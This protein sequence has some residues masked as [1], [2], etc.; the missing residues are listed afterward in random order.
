MSFEILS[1]K[2][3]FGLIFSHFISWT[4]DW[5]C[6]MELYWIFYN[7]KATH[8]RNA[9]KMTFFL[10]IWNLTNFRGSARIKDKKRV[11]PRKVI[12]FQ[13]FWHGLL[14]RDNKFSTVMDVLYKILKYFVCIEIVAKWKVN[15][16]KQF[17]W[18]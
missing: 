18:L 11:W 8:V 4:Y 12:F 5:T 15:L 9:W 17:Y 7:S 13:D 1:K 10:L 2:I 6:L 3:Q 16:E 14:W